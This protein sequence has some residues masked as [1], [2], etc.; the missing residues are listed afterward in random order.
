[1]R[2]IFLV[3][4]LAVLS[5]TSLSGCFGHHSPTPPPE[6]TEEPWTYPDTLL[7]LAPEVLADRLARFGQLNPRLHARMD[8]YGR[9]MPSLDAPLPAEDGV[10]DSTEAVAIARQFLERNRE[11]FYITGDIPAVEHVSFSPPG[12]W[13][14]SFA[15]QTVGG[16]VVFGTWIGVGLDRS[17]YAASG[18]HYPK[19]RLPSEPGLDPAAAAALLPQSDTFQCWS[20]VD[21]FL[22]PTPDVLVLPSEFEPR[23]GSVGLAYRYIYRFW[24]EDERG[25]RWRADGVDAMTGEKIPW[26][27]TVLC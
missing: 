1:M 26:L 4:G 19:V 10:G 3:A 13:S 23:S 25:L 11:F 14:V 9:L 20:R 16:V 17:V 5:G 15:E 22:R 2:T 27:W 12:S 24:Y 8:P 21:I 7:P 18:G 6:A